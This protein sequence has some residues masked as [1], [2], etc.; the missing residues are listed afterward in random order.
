MFSFCVYICACYF[1]SKSISDP[2]VQT[3]DAEIS[4]DATR[5]DGREFAMSKKLAG[6]GS[7]FLV[8]SLL[9]CTTYVSLEPTQD[10]D[11]V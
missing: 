1:P 9:Y 6:I 8:I 5:S 7:R 4:A 11:C 2:D 3:S 10:P